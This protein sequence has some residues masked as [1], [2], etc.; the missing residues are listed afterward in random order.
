MR[1]LS[2]SSHIEEE[3]DRIHDARKRPITFWGYSVSYRQGHP[4]VRIQ[5]T[6]CSLL[7]VRMLEAAVRQ[8]AEVL[9][10]SC[11]GLPYAPVRRQLPNVLRAVNRRRKLAGLTLVEVTC[12]LMRRR[13]CS[14]LE[15]VEPLR[16]WAAGAPGM[17]MRFEGA[18]HNV[19]PDRPLPQ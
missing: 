1:A 4:H 17:A 15:D 11:R 13:I 3:E 16:R 6:D 5:Q 10:S 19:P 12:I 2:L 14:P 9:R 8:E 7:K 18:R